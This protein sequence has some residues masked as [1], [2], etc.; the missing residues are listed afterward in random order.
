MIYVYTEKY[1]P[2]FKYIIHQIFEKILCGKVTVIR[3]LDEAKAC[4]EP[5]IAYSRTEK[6]K[7][8][9]NICP[10]G[11]VFQDGIREQDTTVSE[12]NDTKIFFKTGNGKYDLPFDVLSASF[13]LISRYEEYYGEKDDLDRYKKEDSIAYKNGFLDRPIV[14][15]WAYMLEA[16]L[17][18]KFKYTPAVKEDFRM[19]SSI[20]IDNMYK[21]RCNSIFLT[22]CQLIKKLFT[23]DFESFR[24]QLDVVMFFEKDPYDNFDKIIRFHNHTSLNPSFFVM[25]RKGR[26]GTHN[27]Y[28]LFRTLRKHLRRNYA[29]GL[30]PSIGC[31]K[32]KDRAK[33]ELHRL[34]KFIVKQRVDTNMFD[35]EAFT[36]PVGYETLLK[37]GIRDDYS[38]CYPDAIG[39]RSGTCTPFRF[40]DIKHECKTRLMVHTVSL[41]DIALKN[42]GIHHNVI[43]AAAIPLINRIKNVN[44]QF[45]SCLTNCVFSNSGHWHGWI[46]ALEQVY[47]YASKLE[48]NSIKSAMDQ[49][50]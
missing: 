44:G 22:F 18:K 33:A 21:Y 31:Y 30:H 9:I 10:H 48:V 15:E 13:F 17:I 34:E 14:D 37:I 49:C 1:T 8:A 29:T 23:G 5:L 42:M 19:H 12:W 6:L 46:D 4:K 16:M 11:L 35:K 32:D 50:E 47:K 39:F 2:R 28:T 25:V 36:L 45:C 24:H 26:R 43:E 40:Y 3:D 20:V 41:S 7:N 38:M 27:I